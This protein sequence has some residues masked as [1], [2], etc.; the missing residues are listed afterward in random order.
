VDLFASRQNRQIQQFFSFEHDYEA[1]GTNAFNARWGGLGVVYAY[2][3][4]ILVGRLLQKIRFDR[5][6]NA[7]V[8]IPAWMAQ[9]WWPTM[10]EMLLS[11]PLILPNEPWITQDQW[12]KPTWEG[13]WY[14]IAVNLSGDMHHVRESRRKSWTEAGA[15]SRTGTSRSM[16]RILEDSGVGGQNISQLVDSVHGALRRGT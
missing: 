4:P 9:N 2:P 8:I 10:L 5:V 16:T 3:P 13:K 14:L 12:D 7:V 11:S 1:L 15:P 6:K